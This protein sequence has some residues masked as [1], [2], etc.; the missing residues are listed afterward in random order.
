VD[1]LGAR[2]A[3]RGFFLAGGTAI[4]LQLGH[5]RS[6]DLDWIVPRAMGEPLRLARELRDEGIDLCVAS[7][8]PGVLNAA[9]GSAR[10]S[11]LEHRYPLLDPPVAAAG[12]PI[13]SLRDL[14]A[15]ALATLAR[16]GAKRD[17]VDVY[18]LGIRVRTLPEML[19]DYVRKYRPNGTGSVLRAL[20]RFH[21]AEKERMPELFWDIDWPR[22]R[23]ALSRWVRGMPPG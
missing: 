7:V 19:S 1:A 13:A 17:F 3:A 20:G 2:L 21:D 22:V 16:R 10:V 9:V 11:L 5:R 23:D 4:A 6:L 15:T 14:A 12:A 18:A 8:A